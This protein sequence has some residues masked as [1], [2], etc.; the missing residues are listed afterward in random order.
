[1]ALLVVRVIKGLAAN[2]KHNSSLYPTG[3]FA[4]PKLIALEPSGGLS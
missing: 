2:K 1:M 4:K 3:Y